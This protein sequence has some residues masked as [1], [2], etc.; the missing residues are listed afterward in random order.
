MLAN[1]IVV[2]GGIMRMCAYACKY[3]AW[4]RLGKFERELTRGK[5]NARV[6]D[7]GHAALECSLDDGFAV[8]VEA[9]SVYVSMAIDEQMMC[10]FQS[11]GE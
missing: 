10:P 9:G 7:A 11:L 1:F 3:D 2:G 8:G 4:M 6:N 5:I